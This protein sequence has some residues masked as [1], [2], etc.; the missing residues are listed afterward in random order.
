M[1][2]VYMHRNK[3][4]NKVYIG[5]TNDIKRRW[6]SNGVEYRSSISFYGAI[7]KYGFDA[8]EHLILQ[9]TDDEKQAFE[10]EKRYINEYESN[11]KKKGYN[12]SAGGNGGKIYKNHPRN[13]LGKHQTD[14]QKEN[15]SR[16]MSD[17]DFNPMKNGAVKWGVTHKHP[18]GMMGKHHSEEHN[19]L[20]SEKLKGRVHNKP[21]RVIFPDGEIKIFQTMKDAEAIGLCKPV[22]LKILRSKKP[23][24]VKVVNQYTERV[25]HLAG[26]VIE[27]LEN[28]EI[29]K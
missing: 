16:L 1:Y 19:Q 3:F 21:I 29:T 5:V 24:E 23:Y 9:E 26:I 11:S 22:I 14:F 25:K 10:L 28:T 13:M 27:Y 7:L 12:I 6:R 15:Q 2:Y 17:S 20:V 4:N 8:F 18:R